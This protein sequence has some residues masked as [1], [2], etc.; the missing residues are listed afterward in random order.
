MQYSDIHIHSVPSKTFSFVS[1]LTLSLIYAKLE[2]DLI[3]N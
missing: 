2:S 3:I 1:L